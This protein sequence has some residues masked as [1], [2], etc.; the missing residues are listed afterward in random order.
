MHILL[1]SNTHLLFTQPHPH[2]LHTTPPTPT[3]PQDSLGGNSRTLMVAC[4]SPADV[5]LEESINTLRYASRA[6]N[7]RN[8]PVVNRDPVAAEIAH[9]RQ[10]LAAARGEIGAL[11]RRLGDEGDAGV[12]GGEGDVGGGAVEELQQRIGMLEL[13]NARLKVELETAK[14]ESGGAHKHMIEAQ[15]ER[16]VLRLKLQELTETS[17][18]VCVVCRCLMCCCNLVCARAHA[19]V[20]HVQPTAHLCY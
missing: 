5:N 13:D 7:I 10:L 20:I 1:Y 14:A 16:D 2:I 18:G 8:K 15:A 6:R 11:K 19:C 17:T 12:G 4:V 9:L 3:Q